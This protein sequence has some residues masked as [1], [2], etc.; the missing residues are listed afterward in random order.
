M[1]A[2]LDRDRIVDGG[3]SVRIGAAI[4]RCG[5]GG[6]FQLPACSD[7]VGRGVDGGAVGHP[8]SEVGVSHVGPSETVAEQVLGDAP[9]A[10]V[11]A[12]PVRERRDGCLIGRSGQFGVGRHTSMGSDEH[13][14]GLIVDE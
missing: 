12:G 6:E 13:R 14:G 4:G 10:V 2:G 3:S 1:I 8:A 11:A 9:P 5:V 7:G